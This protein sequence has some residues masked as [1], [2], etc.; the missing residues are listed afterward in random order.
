M[1]SACQ[2]CC[3][4]P[5]G[6]AAVGHILVTIVLVLTASTSPA[7][8]APTTVVSAL[9]TSNLPPMAEDEVR[10]RAAPAIGLESAERELNARRPR[11]A[12]DAAANGL[13]TAQ[14]RPL[15]QRLL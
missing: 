14:P 7:P 5:V 10:V 3:M 13:D 9:G 2:N 12:A 15:R 1:H 11:E 8:L 4:Q 6:S